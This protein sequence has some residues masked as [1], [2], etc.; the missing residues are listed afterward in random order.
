[1]GRRSHGRALQKNK[2]S[3]MACKKP[4]M[5]QRNN[6]NVSIEEYDD[7][8]DKFHKGADKILLDVDRDSEFSE[9]DA[10]EPV[11]DLKAGSDSAE[12]EEGEDEEDE[13]SDDELD[14]DELSGIAAKMA[15]QARLLKQKA[16]LT[17]EDEDD[18][19]EHPDKEH[20]AWGKRK[21][22]YYNADNIDYELL[23]S[24]EEEA[25]VEEEAEALRL[26]RQFA[27]SL[28]PED[29]DIDSEE[30]GGSAEDD[31]S[32]LQEVVAAVEAKGQLN[33]KRFL[34]DI[35][36][37]GATARNTEVHIE[38]VKEDVNAQLNADKSTI[39]S[40]DAPELLGLLTQLKEHSNE[41][42]KRIEPLLV[43]GH[44]SHDFPSIVHLV[45]IHGVLG[46]LRL[47][48]E[49]LQSQINRLATVHTQSLPKVRERETSKSSI[50]VQTK[51][52]Q[53]ESLQ[54]ASVT[55]AL[56]SCTH[57]P[58]NVVQK[59]FNWTSIES[60]DDNAVEGKKSLYKLLTPK[61]R[62]AKPI[63]SGDMDLPLKEDLGSRR[64][65]VERKIRQKLDSI[66]DS[67][68]DAIEDEYYQEAKR[69]RF[70]KITT[71]EKDSV[72]RIEVT[73]AEPDV[74]KRHISYEMEKNKGL[75]PY[76][77]KLTKNPRKKY[78][79]KHEKAVIRRKGQVREIKHPTSSYGGEA[80]GIRT[81]ISRSVRF[82]S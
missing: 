64:A 61:V 65:Q 41:L 59:Q 25:L 69:Q 60:D 22:V 77:K 67:D 15:K 81:T 34:S 19:T 66:E 43:K 8:I 51:P 56:D 82:H 46:K 6:H 55:E 38:E 11:F 20:G 9:E 18:E 40:S 37:I 53:M 32:S 39:I 70:L 2:G 57:P 76:R 16:N 33:F 36:R 12:D 7:E 42:D 28:R 27:E 35:A 44:S 47:V 31:E 72:R 26:Q 49:K 50:E 13:D 79:L 4:K 29:F 21:K 80:T 48:D 54:M 52:S 24:D 75:T 73:T 78:K 14:E 68:G 1:M 3:G 30:D 45:E 74:G 71:K 5:Q 62:K 58:G 23:S 63:M 17:D 10:E